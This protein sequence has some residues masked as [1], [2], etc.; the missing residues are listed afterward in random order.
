M[1][2]NRRGA[3]QVPRWQAV[4][5]WGAGLGVLLT[6][7]GCGTVGRSDHQPAIASAASA[8]PAL[9]QPVSAPVTPSAAAPLEGSNLTIAQV[10]AIARDHTPTRAV[11]DANRAAAQAAVVQAQAIANPDVEVEGG[12]GRP[13]TGGSSETIGRIALRQRLELPGKRSSRVHAAESG[14][15]VTEQ[16]ALALGVDLEAT[17]REAVADYAGATLAATQASQA[18]E[19]ATRIAET[20]QRRVT[21]GEGDRGDA[22]RAE[23][24]RRQAAINVDHRQQMVVAARV[25]LTA[26]CGGGLPITFTVTDAWDDAW[27]PTRDEVLTAAEH[28]PRLERQRALR[29]QRLAEVQ[30]EEAAGR[31]DVTVGAFAGRAT[32]AT[33]VGLTVAVDLPVWNRN[34]GG[35]AAAQADLQRSDAEAEVDRRVLR[36]SID[37][38]WAA[39]QAAMVR[40]NRLAT[41]VEPMTADLLKLRIQTYATGDIGLL[42]VLDAR[43][44]SQSIADD[45]LT[46]RMEVVHA[47]IQLQIALGR[48]APVVPARIPE[49]K[50]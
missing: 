42:E 45:I 50:P 6:V 46:S 40:R 13:R 23:L 21:A 27:T 19:L 41:E 3:Q 35:I 14:L 10:V 47:C 8:A 15:A 5:R 17:V 2:R 22:L 24:D 18:A 34:H 36:Q 32:D 30:R 12:Q 25:A 39:Y 26:I 11:L 43:R 29:A 37:S 4:G 33:E 31:P 16:D 49:I 28:H 44:T 48:F 20:V 7:S 9:A 1:Q 38:A